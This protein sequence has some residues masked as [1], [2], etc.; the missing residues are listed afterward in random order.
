VIA[1][2]ANLPF[3]SK[4]FEG[5]VTLHTIHHLPET[6]H[7]RAFEELFRVL[8]PGCTA[9]I[10]NG[11]ARSKMMKFFEPFVRT[12]YMI[13]HAYFRFRGISFQ[14]SNEEDEGLD[15]SQEKPA[16]RTKVRKGTYTNKHDAAWV[17]SEVGA[18]MPVRILVW[19]SVTV[20]FMRALIHPMLGGQVWLRLLYWLEECFPHFFGVNGKYPMLV[21]TKEE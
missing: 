5:I 17:K 2:V 10:V 6:E 18:L 16:G 15:T 20:R 19:R 3:Q 1:D 11:W 4:A 12:A 9:V 21:I 13:R 7:M 14:T 8:S